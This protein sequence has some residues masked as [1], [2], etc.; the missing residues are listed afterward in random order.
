[1]AQNS[2]AL[3]GV[4]R[5]TATLE[6]PDGGCVVL[7]ESNMYDTVRQ[8][9]QSHHRYDVYGPG[10]TLTRTHLHRLDLAY[11]Y[12]GDIKRLLMQSGFRSVQ[13]AGG[14]DGRPFANDADELV[15]EAAVD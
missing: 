15:V 7:S 4:W 9:V 11:L 2:G 6:R 1:M 8:V 10:G 12:P 13:I 14:F 5:R 3:A